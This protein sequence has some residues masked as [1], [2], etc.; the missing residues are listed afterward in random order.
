MD[1]PGFVPAFLDPDYDTHI[2]EIE[3]IERA[4]LSVPVRLTQDGLTTATVLSPARD[5]E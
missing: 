2:T 4:R 3:G 5:T 1:W